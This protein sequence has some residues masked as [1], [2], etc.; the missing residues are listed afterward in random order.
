M[1]TTKRYVQMTFWEGVGDEKSQCSAPPCDLGH[2]RHRP[3]EQYLKDRVQCFPP[4]PPFP[5]ACPPFI[6]TCQSWIYCQN[7]E[8]R[9]KGST[10][11]Q[12]KSGYKSDLLVVK[13]YVSPKR[14]ISTCKHSDFVPRLIVRYILV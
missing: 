7:T 2:C 9:Q 13:N 11:A 6:S 4:S 5:P 12:V 8:E 14:S 3:R 10:F 1:K